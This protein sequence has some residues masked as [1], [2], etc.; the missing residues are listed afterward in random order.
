MKKRPQ[1]NDD[2]DDILSISK[3]DILTFRIVKTLYWYIIR[4]E[5]FTCHV[6]K[7]EKINPVIAKNF[8]TCVYD[9]SSRSKLVLAH[10]LA[11]KTPPI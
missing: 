10:T 7:C 2:E 5:R 3:D 1:I 6:W 8:T 9:N 11:Y 4:E